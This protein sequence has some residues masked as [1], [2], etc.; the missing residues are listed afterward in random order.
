MRD[1]DLREE[2]AAWLRPVREAEPPGLPVI[3]RR[4]RLRRARQAAGGTAALAAVAG[5]AVAVSATLGSPRA[6]AG[7]Q[8]TT[9]P[10]TG[11]S[12]I[13]ATTSSP[14]PVQGGS[15][16]SSTYAVSA[17]V[18]TLVVSSG[19][20]AVTITGSQRSTVAVTEQI[21]FSARPPAMMRTLAAKTLMLGYQCPR[22]SLCAAAYDIQV[23]R[24][25]A[26]RVVSE[27]GEI[28]LSSLAGTVTAG[29]GAGLISAAGLTSRTASF[30]TS[31]G[32]INAVFA[33]APMTVHVATDQGSINLRV[34]GTV[35]YDVNAPP[36]ELD[37]AIVTV[38][39]SSSSRHV[40]DATCK[41]GSLL[42]GPS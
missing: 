37:S 41:A 24:G 27:T 23:P 2:F 33:A 30:T 16:T 21:Q 17:P 18:S 19:A 35:S 20:G 6:P 34:P 5:I 25:V 40:I 14:R 22:E 4:L 29:S 11:A 10:L 8:G 15:Q 36:G 39:R 32:E 13:P 28:R 1:E 3:R 26:V 12:S 7:P 9:S 38:P 31:Q 42:I